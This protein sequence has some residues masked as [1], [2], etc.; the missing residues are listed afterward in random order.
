VFVPLEFNAYLCLQPEQPFQ[1]IPHA[2]FPTEPEKKVHRYGNNIILH[3]D[4]AAY[5]I[6][7]SGEM[8]ED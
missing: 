2:L 5:D 8:T 1:Q 3:F 6:Y 4:M 7:L